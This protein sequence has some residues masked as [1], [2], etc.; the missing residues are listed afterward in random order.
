MREKLDFKTFDRVFIVFL[1]VGAVAAAMHVMLGLYHLATIA[2]VAFAVGLVMLGL[3]YSIRFARRF[4]PELR[5]LTMIARPHE[6]ISVRAVSVEGKCAWGYRES[7]S[8]VIGTS[9][10]A[11]P[12]ICRAAADA[13]TPALHE[14]YSPGK[15]SEFSCHC[16]LTDRRVTFAWEPRTPV[17][18]TP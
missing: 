1:G 16:P 11:M 13:L 9:G 3:D 15:P 10:W 5:L 17:A 2:T 8:W 14:G 4:R 18:I 7:D 12:G 6:P